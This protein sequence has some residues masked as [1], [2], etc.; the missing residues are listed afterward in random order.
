MDRR[1]FFRGAVLLTG[2]LFIPACS[3][4]G[5]HGIADRRSDFKAFLPMK[6]DPARDGL[7]RVR[8]Y[9][10]RANREEILS[11]IERACRGGKA[12]SSIFNPKTEEGYYVNCNPRNRQLLNGYVPVNPAVEPRGRP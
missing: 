6:Q 8:P 4:G 11:A 1:T 10:K 2:P 9:F 3:T 5:Q 12:G 7:K